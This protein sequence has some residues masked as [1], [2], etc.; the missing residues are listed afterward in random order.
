MGRAGIRAQEAAGAPLTYGL[1]TGKDHLDDVGQYT[2]WRG[3]TEV[4]ERS[5][6]PNKDGS[7]YTCATWASQGYESCAVWL[8]AVTMAGLSTSQ[9][10]QSHDLSAL[11]T[12]SSVPE[13]YGSLWPTVGPPNR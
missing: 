3:I 9:S 10:L 8:D 6:I 5:D 13:G 4:E 2:L 12:F 7:S 11:S 1:K